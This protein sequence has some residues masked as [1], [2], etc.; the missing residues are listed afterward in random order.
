MG[1]N[2]GTDIG[3][4]DDADCLAEFEDAGVYKTDGDNGGC[5]RT[6]YQSGDSRA[7]Q[8]A[9]PDASG[10]LFKD[11]G[12]LAAGH[13]F[14]AGAEHMHSVKE[15]GKSAQHV[16]KVKNSY[17]DNFLLIGDNKYLY[18]RKMRLC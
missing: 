1:S 8:N 13:F 15:E 2:G 6:L 4:H 14:K 16:Y 3:T 7:E 11:F 9:F 10:K 12:K 18:Y 5:G 17:Q